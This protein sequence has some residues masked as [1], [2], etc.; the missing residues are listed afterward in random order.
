MTVTTLHEHGDVYSLTLPEAMGLS[1][2]QQYAVFQ[3][4]NGTI[5]LSPK[6]PNKFEGAAAGSE[7]ESDTEYAYA[8]L[9]FGV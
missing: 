1:D 5:I 9:E 8:A 4:D 7:A 2:G 6:Q 3:E